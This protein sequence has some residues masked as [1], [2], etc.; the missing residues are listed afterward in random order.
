MF[1]AG[2]NYGLLVSYLDEAALALDSHVGSGTEPYLSLLWRYHS[3]FTIQM[4]LVEDMGGE[5]GR[6]SPNVSRTL[7]IYYRMAMKQSSCVI[8]RKELFLLYILT[9]NG[10][11]ERPLWKKQSRVE[12]SESSPAT[13]YHCYRIILR[14]A[15][16]LDHFSLYLAYNT[17]PLDRPV[18]V[19]MREEVFHYLDV[20]AYVLAQ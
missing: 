4:C 17:H 9:T 14:P 20:V 7:E 18:K 11:N 8:S 16:S 12:D 2:P 5:E 1:F 3:C 10:W 15:L 13:P 6:K 19:Q